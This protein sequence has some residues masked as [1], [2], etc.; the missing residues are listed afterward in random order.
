[1]LRAL[2]KVQTARRVINLH[3]DAIWFEAFED[4]EKHVKEMT[5]RKKKEMHE[6]KATSEFAPYAVAKRYKEIEE[7]LW[8]G[9]YGR[10]CQSTHTA[11]RHRF[12]FL[13]LTSSV[14][15]S[16]SL[17]RAELSDFL[18]LTV[19][20]KD[21]D[22]HPMFLMINSI[23]I[24]KTTHGNMEEQRDM[25]MSIFVQS[26]LSLQIWIIGSTTHANSTTLRWKTGP[27]ERCGLASSF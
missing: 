11:L 17:Y 1:M 15:W 7:A 27:I 3:W 22:V 19:P 13:C 24:G 5:P 25:R 14:L 4:L 12:C 26:V 6:E 8:I 20:K 9:G 10:A 16:K 18:S 23:A 21:K 2:Y